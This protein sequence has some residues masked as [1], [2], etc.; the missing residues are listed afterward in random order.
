MTIGPSALRVIVFLAA[1]TLGFQAPASTSNTWFSSDIGAPA[2]STTNLS[3]NGGVLFEA[4]FDT[5]TMEGDLVARAIDRNG[6]VQA[7]EFYPLDPEA[8]DYVAGSAGE[9]RT[10][11]GIWRAAIRVTAQSRRHNGARRDNRVIITSGN[12]SSG[13]S[14]G[15]RF[16]WDNSANDALTPAMKSLIN[17]ETPVTAERDPVVDWIRGHDASEGDGAGALRQRHSVL[18]NLMYGGPVFLGPPAGYSN[19]PKYDDFRLAHRNR[20]ELVF[21][22]GSDGMLHAFDAADGSELFAYIPR[23]VLGELKQRTLPHYTDTPLVA[24][25]LAAGDAYGVFPGCAVPPC[26]RSVLVGSLGPGGRSVYALDVTNPRSDLGESDMES[27]AARRIVLWEFRHEHLGRSSSR[28]LITKLG[29]G[30]WVVVFGNGPGTGRAVLFVVDASSGELLYE[31]ET[32]ST[33]ST[34][35]LSPPVAWD[36]G[37]DGDVDTVYAGDLEGNLWKFDFSV[38][39]GDPDDGRNP[40]IALSGNSLLKVVE[41][42]SPEAH[43]VSTPTLVSLRRDGSLMV[44]FGSSG[45]KAAGDSIYGIRDENRSWGVDPPLAVHTLGEIEPAGEIDSAAAHSYRFISSSTS[46]D[47]PVG[48]QLQ[49][50]PGEHVVRGLTLSDQRIEFISAAAK[51]PGTTENWFTGVD[52]ITGG[53]PAL[54]FLDLDSNGSVDPEDIFTDV[55]DDGDF[56]PGD[57]LK[58]VGRF[59]GTGIVSAAAEAVTSGGLSVMFVSRGPVPKGPVRSGNPGVPGGRFDEDNFDWSP[60][61]FSACTRPAADG[62]GSS[63]ATAMSCWGGAGDFSV[64]HSDGY[65][66][67]WDTEKEPSGST[68]GDPSDNGGDNGSGSDPAV[69]DGAG[70]S[71]LTLNIDASG[72]LPSDGRVS[73]RQVLE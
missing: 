44:I 23:T 69:I 17:S 66:D 64:C 22:G 55:N 32:P 13:T 35:G 21:A 52:F 70:G 28:P 1:A 11:K 58:P 26:W 38:A 14:R 63:C 73:W 61:Q 5:H 39:T 56:T 47:G 6:S 62:Q 65:D 53:T 4:T 7:D 31:I 33:G 19:D 12:D 68:N 30:T 9:V 37:H 40:F 57:D 54:P 27:N 71:T 45:T 36:A 18:G 8:A 41:A 15:R 46:P 60:D 49:L 29:D 25:P 51:S 10:F 67:E 3:V 2:L 72:P 34:N 20:P 43:P 42:D 16:Q 59:L 48:W 24:G 50:P